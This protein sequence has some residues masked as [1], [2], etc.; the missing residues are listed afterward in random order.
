MMANKGKRNE[1][2]EGSKYMLSVSLF[3]F[4]SFYFKPENGQGATTLQKQHVAK[5]KTT[6]RSIF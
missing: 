5:R 4:H 6:D 1:E 2:V 3:L